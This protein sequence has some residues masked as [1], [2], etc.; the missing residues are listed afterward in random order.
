MITIL[1]NLLDRNVAA[2]FNYET[3]QEAF[4]GAHIMRISAIDSVKLT[5]YPV[6]SGESRTDG[7]RIIVPSECTIEF[8]LNRDIK[9]V[10]AE[11]RRGFSE[12]D[13]YTIQ[14]RSGTLERFVISEIPRDEIPDV[15]G[16]A[17]IKVRFQEWKEVEPEYGE[18]PLRVVSN[19]SDSDT[20]QV[21]Q[22]QGAPVNDPQ[23]TTYLNKWFGD[24]IEAI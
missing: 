2:I 6:E 19:P 14:T 22:N 18:M 12:G 23:K 9:N 8:I 13:R 3:A 11:I 10:F 1:K 17:A 20:V 21:G 7:H 4:I 24:L 5:S 16:S 15:E